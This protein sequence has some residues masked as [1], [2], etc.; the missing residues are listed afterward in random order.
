VRDALSRLETEG[1]ILRRQG[2]GTFINQAGLMV[3]SRLSDIV[4]YQNLIQEYGSRPAIELISTKVLRHPPTAKKLHRAKDEPLLLVKKRFLADNQPVIFSC[5]YL[6]VH[7]IQRAYTPDDLRRPVFDF[8]PEFCNQDFSYFL[9]ELVPLIPPD[10][11]ASVLKLPA[12]KNALVSFEEV[13]YNQNNDPII[14]A[15]SYF[16]DDLLRL[17]LI[18]QTS[19]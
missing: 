9:T 14:T 17:R 10:W 8:I 13:G 11:L 1:I 3:K 19:P 7:I 18:R 4:P 5:T 12:Q 2:A 15:T 16:R 6:P